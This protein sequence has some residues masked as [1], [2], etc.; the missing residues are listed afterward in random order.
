MVELLVVIA[1]IGILAAVVTISLSDARKKSR[2]ARRIADLQQISLALE[3][4]YDS[5]K[6]PDGAGSQTSPYS[7]PTS[8]SILQAAG[9]IARAPVDPQTNVA[10]SYAGLGSGA[11]CDSYHLVATLEDS[12]N[13]AL[14][15]DTDAV[16]G[17]ACT[18]SAG[19][20]TGVDTSSP[21]YDIKP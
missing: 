7:Y 4:Y 10:Y 11:I 3:N 16:S 15:T 1:I 14:N 21:F 8:L 20:V 13:P 6:G 12:S 18:G 2:D 9:F 5:K 19:D 17:A